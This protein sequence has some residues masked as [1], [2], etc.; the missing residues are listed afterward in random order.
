[1]SSAPRESVS[2][3]AS[4]TSPN[5]SASTRAA[6]LDAVLATRDGLEPILQRQR[7]RF[8]DIVAFARGH[9]PLYRD[10]YRDLPP[11]CA[12]PARVPAVSKRALMPNFDAWVTDPLVNR[13]LVDDWLSRTDTI[14]D[15]LLGRYLVATTS[16]STG[17]P[18]IIL[19]DGPSRAVCNAE[20]VRA[21]R[22]MPWPALITSFVRER[23]RMAVIVATGGHYAAAAMIEYMKRVNP[24][25]AGA[26]IIAAGT[27]IAEMVDLLNRE[28][29]YALS[30][31]ASALELLA[32]EQ[33][34]GRLHVA[35]AV[36]MST[37]ETLSDTGRNAVATAFGC[38]VIDGY[39]ATEAPA[40]ALSCRYGRMHQNADWILLEPID[41]AGNA[42]EP[43]V[44]SH[45]LLVTNFA[46]RVQPIVRYDLGDRITV[47]PGGCPCGSPLPTIRVEGRTDDVLLFP[48]RDGMLVP[49]LPLPLGAEI[50]ADPGVERFQA[51][52]TGRAALDIRLQS[53][54]GAD[55][56]RTWEGVCARASAHL[57][58][59][60]IAGVVIRR[61]S[62]PPQRA[63]G[64]K[65]RQ[66][67]RAPGLDP[68][69]GAP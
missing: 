2:L 27:P 43:G 52:Q 5:W 65:F 14:G 17:H 47:T 68:E 53:A 7:A 15:V 31:Y 64:G 33:Q 63:E 61:D 59:Q 58:R 66:V 37:A 1:M 60:G 24:A 19:L 3:M 36:V 4:H 23:G 32:G 34:A 39:G 11:G 35:P 13:R 9:S 26:R 25:A 62:Q 40:I 67:F 8:A 22:S 54:P 42:V 44:T 55:E 21:L 12:D 46:N 29:P 10:L 38:P 56:D 20:R 69:Q 48:R 50:E 6:A 28:P 30:G 16:G 57:E 18:A 45:S 51:V 41:E 49:V